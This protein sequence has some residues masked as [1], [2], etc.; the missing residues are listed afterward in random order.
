MMSIWQ[1]YSMTGEGG[2]VVAAPLSLINNILLAVKHT[3]QKLQG[4]II[5]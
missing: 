3:K 2:Q 5:Q 4:V 1:C